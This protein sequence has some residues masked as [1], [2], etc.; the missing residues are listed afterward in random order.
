MAKIV[1]RVRKET[2]ELYVMTRGPSG[3]LEFGDPAHGDEKHHSRK[4][5]VTADTLED[6]LEL[7]RQ[8]LH[9]RMSGLATGQFNMISPKNLLVVDVPD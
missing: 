2:G 1:L 5:L 3:K 9:P 8:N 4:H 7:I 6:A